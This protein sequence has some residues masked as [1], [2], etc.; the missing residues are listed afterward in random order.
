MAKMTVYVPDELKSRMDKTKEPVNWSS[1]ACEAFER[2]LGEIAQRKKEKT[3]ED[4]IQRLKASKL[5]D[6]SDQHRQGYEDG[7]DW[8]K[9]RASA[10][11]LRRLSK[12]LVRGV[13]DSFP[14]SDTYDPGQAFF[15]L[16]VS[17]NDFDRR[18]SDEFWE[19]NAGDEGESLSGEV[20]YVRGFA[21]GALEVWNEVEDKI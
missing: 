1:L 14:D 20:E 18:D 6:T 21:E 19:T 13:E 7:I 15:R 17:E 16:L 5:E 4:V 3:M 8:A 11:E 10:R 12:E 9:H 2:K